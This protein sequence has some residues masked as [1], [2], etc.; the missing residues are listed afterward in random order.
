MGTVINCLPGSHLRFSINILYF[1]TV[2]L[3]ARH[4][5]QR[6]RG[7][8]EDSLPSTTSQGLL[9]AAHPQSSPT[10]PSPLAL[11]QFHHPYIAWRGCPLPTQVLS[12]NS[13]QSRSPAGAR[14]CKK[15]PISA[16][17][18]PGHGLPPQA[19]CCI[20]CTPL[21][22]R[23]RRALQDLLVDKAGRLRRWGNGQGAG[24]WGGKLE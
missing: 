20:L 24:G 3:G 16:A 8:T 5:S 18:H 15:G 11:P 10:R 22:P 14:K 9:T 7:C 1:N 12:A 6:T 13:P 2:T 4:P 17:Q 21:H 23:T 19:P